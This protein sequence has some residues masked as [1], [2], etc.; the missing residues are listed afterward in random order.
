MTILYGTG[1]EAGSKEIIPSGDAQSFANIA[2]VAT[3]V[4]TGNFRLNIGDGGG[5]VNWVRFGDFASGFTELYATIWL[6]PAGAAKELGVE[7]ELTDNT[8]VGV[9]KEAGN[10]DLHAYVNGAAVDVGTALLAATYNLVELYV[11]I[12]GGNGRIVVKVNGVNDI[13]F[14]GGTKPTSATDIQYLRLSMDNGAGD[15]WRADDLTIRTDDFPGDIRYIKSAPDGDDS[16]TWTRSAGA[17][18]FSLVDETPPSD[19]DYVETAVNTNQDLYTLVDYALN[20]AISHIVQWIRGL[21]TPSGGEFKMQIKSGGTTSEESTSGLATSA[22]YVSRILEEDPNTLAAW[23]KTAFNAA[24][25]GQEAV[26]SSETVR[27]TQHIIE[28]AYNE[29]LSIGLRPLEMD[30]DLESGSR[31]WITSWEDGSLFLKRLPSTL[32]AGVSFSFGAATENEVA[33]RTFYLSPLAAPF[34]GTANL[35]DIIY[36]YGRWDDGAVTHIEKSTD[37]GST[38][39]DIG[40]SATW[41]TGWIGAFLIAD[42]NTLFAFVN[43]ASR[44]LYRTIDAGVTWTSL[45]SLPFDVDPGGVSGH[46]DGRILISN[47]DAGA[48]TAAYAVA[49]DYSSWID[50]TGSPSFPASTPGAGSNAIIWIV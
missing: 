20:N 28:I 43:G 17:T 23:G 29:N 10:Q 49:P 5:G 34:F 1:F 41:L 47:R 30:V 46:P 22:E 31:V 45:S 4:H 25:V 44:A 26:V 11:K 27:V 36:V 38:F 2:V 32:A 42:V 12:D 7:F 3:S 35:N 8:L 18:N 13:D 40:D 9:R 48:Q 19:A 14:T 50:A 16:V 24:L 37:G 21:S 39:T 15:F 6:D 33:I